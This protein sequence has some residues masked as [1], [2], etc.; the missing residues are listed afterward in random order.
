MNVVVDENI[1]LVTVQEFRGLGH[2]VLDFRG[3]VQQGMPD[4]KLWAECQAQR[5]LLITT[6]KGFIEYASLPHWGILVIRLRHPNQFRIHQRV[7]KAIRQHPPEQ[8]PGLLVVIR[9]RVK[10]ERRGPRPQP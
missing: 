6:D 5:R 2:N 7:M 8:W 10:T 3:T 4:A 9:D 1:P